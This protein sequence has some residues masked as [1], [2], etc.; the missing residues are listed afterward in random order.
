MKPPA[1][2]ATPSAMALFNRDIT[3]QDLVVRRDHPL[4]GRCV[5]VSAAE[6]L[7]MLGLA[8][9]AVAQPTLK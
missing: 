5:R 3:H 2:C 6:H 8:G 4:R 7:R 9:V 1:W